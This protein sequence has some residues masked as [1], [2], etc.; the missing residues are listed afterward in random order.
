MTLDKNLDRILNLDPAAALATRGFFSSYPVEEC[1]IKNDCALITGTSDH[2]WIHL[3]GKDKGDLAYLLERHGDLSPYYYSVE[4]WMLPLILEQHGEDWRMETIRYVL[5]PSLEQPG[6]VNQT[7]PMGVDLAEYVFAHSDYKDYTGTDYIRDR[8][9]RGISTQIMKDGSPAAW[10]FTHDDGAL[11]FLHVL[12][13]HRTKGYARDIVLSLIS[14]K[15]ENGL[16]VFC[17]ILPHNTPAIKLVES[18]GFEADRK[19]FWVR[20]GNREEKEEIQSL[21]S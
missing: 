10:G 2:L 17:N 20:C 15:R 19:V 12:P 7:R 18:L 21:W 1:H 5:A 3:A 6:R 11:G 8:L 9:S 14:Q 4:E 13:E 16:P